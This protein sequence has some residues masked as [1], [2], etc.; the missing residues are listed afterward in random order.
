MIDTAIGTETVT[1]KFALRTRLEGGNS[2]RLTRW[3]SDSETGVLRD[4]L[5][6]PIDNFRNILPTNS[7]NRAKIRDGFTLD[8]EGARSQ[9][10]ELLSIFRD[11]GIK[12]HITAADP[13]LPLQIWARDGSFMTPWG[14]VISQMAQWWRRGEYG[15]VIDFCF[16]N[17]LP[18]YEKITAGCLEGGDFMCI[19]DGAALVGY[20]GARSNEAG[21]RQVQRWLQAEGWDVCMYEFDEFFV[22]ADVTVAMLTDTLAGVCTDV[23]PDHVCD[24][25]RALGI[26]IMDVPY[27]H[28]D[29]LGLNVMVLGNDRAV[30][31]SS[32]TYLAEQCRAVGIEVFDPDVSCITAAG[33]GIHC[34]C[35][36][37]TRDP[38]G[39]K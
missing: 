20:S 37:L 16:Q 12:V 17:E 5:I 22:H 35:Q 18:I 4:V 6:G 19:R 10:Q 7:I 13:D 38:V 31:A 3:G 25:L 34:M 1:D 14:M 32:A 23:V 2:A 21:A 11:N 8:V 33:G 27:K 26:E 29:A 30:M 36:P 24:W 28:A 9:Y 15:P 39:Y